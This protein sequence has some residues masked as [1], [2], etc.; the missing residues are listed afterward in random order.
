MSN[1]YRERDLERTREAQAY[2]P[3]VGDGMTLCYPQDSYPLVIV[4]VS[5]SGKTVWVDR[6]RP[7]DLSTGHK[8]ARY[9][10][11]FPVWS[12]TYTD[13][14]RETMRENREPI[15]VTRSRD[16]SYWTAN[17]VNVAYGGARYHRN[18]SY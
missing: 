3:R 4:R 15:K 14:E 8:P 7:V 13:E 10:G 6:L 1:Y 9:D 2:V 12:H 16:G 18:Y 17:G 11:P 5:P